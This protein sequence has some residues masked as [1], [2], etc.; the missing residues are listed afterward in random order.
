MAARGKV[1]SSSVCWLEA[2]GD[3]GSGC[4]WPW[5]CF[6]LTT[7]R[8]LRAM[9]ALHLVS[10]GMSWSGTALREEKSA[11][12]PLRHTKKPPPPGII[13]HSGRRW[14]VGNGSTFLQALINPQLAVY[15]W[16]HL[17]PSIKQAFGA[18][19]H[20]V[21]LLSEQYFPSLPLPLHGP[22]S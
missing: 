16:E 10:R 15:P 2:S 9:G 20:P 1:S 11:F 4:S 12:T 7:S 22:K 14:G 19:R 6:H 3:E 5:L 21:I 8:G 18:L 13:H 17:W